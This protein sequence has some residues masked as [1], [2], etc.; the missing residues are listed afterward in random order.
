MNAPVQQP[1]I[2]RVQPEFFSVGVDIA[3]AAQ[4]AT[5]MP[6]NIDEMM[7][8][9]S[10]AQRQ[11]NAAGVWL[12]FTG[13]GP[14]GHGLAALVGNDHETWGRVEEPSV[15]TARRQ[16]R[17]LELGGLAVAPH[18]QRHGIARLLQEA[19]LA[20]AAHYGYLAVA[21]AWNASPGSMALCSG[22]GRAVAAH[23]DLP[24]TLFV[25]DAPRGARP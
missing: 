20:Y 24:I 10:L 22:A 11:R 3:A 13:E 16:G 21:A 6:P 19:R 12:A 23:H 1:L 25:L 8:R 15:V 18:A 14:A 7:L 2:Q 5:G 9:I 4:K 17:L